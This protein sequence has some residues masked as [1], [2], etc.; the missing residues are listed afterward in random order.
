M[1]DSRTPYL[2]SVA[3]DGLLAGRELEEAAELLELYGDTLNRKDKI[4]FGWIDPDE[5]GVDRAYR[6]GIIGGG[7]TKYVGC[8]T[9]L[10]D[11][12]DLTVTQPTYFDRPAIPNNLR[13]ERRGT[14]GMTTLPNAADKVIW[15]PCGKCGPCREWRRRL[16]AIL[17]GLGKRTVKNE[18]VNQTL[19]R[20]S[21]FASDDYTL[22][23]EYAES[24]RRRVGG[25]RLRLLR[26]GDD[27]MPELVQIYDSE[28][29]PDTIELIERDMS[30]KGLR[31][32]V[33]V[34]LVTSAMVYALIDSEPTR[35]GTRR[36]A[37][38]RRPTDPDTINRETAH[39]A[40]WPKWAE[41]EHDYV[42]GDIDVTADDP[43]PPEV[44]ETDPLEKS[45]YRLPLNERA[46]KAVAMRMQGQTVN[47]G[48]FDHLV[49][50]LD[51]PA[52]VAESVLSIQQT[53][54]PVVSRQLLTDVAGWVV[55]PDG[56]LWRDCWRPVTDAVGIP[57][58]DPTCLQC[59]RQTPAVTPLHL[60]GCC[61]LEGGA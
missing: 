29:D 26:R 37:E 1:N 52:A 21:G 31:G 11:S 25:K 36:K 50:S 33:S 58:P 9:V 23:V 57:S 32:S 8:V 30:R 45:L 5:N 35:E 40:A 18:T 61:E 3:N 53:T 54:G 2:A 27:Y 28:I 51:D 60:C 34:G 43:T 59:G 6:T 14:W 42:H 39:F 19:V 13:C 47:P 15:L 44:T 38:Y 7:D 4:A 48:L 16:I 17:Y 12:Q 55:D 24:L 56:V 41:P 22:P 10:P 49:A 46:I 20:V